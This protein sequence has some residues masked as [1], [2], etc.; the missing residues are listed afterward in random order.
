MTLIERL[1]CDRGLTQ[2][3]VEIG[4][5]VNHKTLVKYEQA[6]TD[7]LV[8]TTLAKLAAFYEV[9]ASDLLTDLR[10]VMAERQ[11]LSDAA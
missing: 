2:R 11:G 6:R 9:P 4:S 10:R 1:R 5:G 7:R 8:F 3:E